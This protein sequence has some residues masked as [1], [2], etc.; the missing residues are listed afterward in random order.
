MTGIA[1]TSDTGEWSP[2]HHAATNSI[3]D[4]SQMDSWFHQELDSLL[5][6]RELLQGERALP[7]LIASPVHAQLITPSPQQSIK[8]LSVARQRWR[9]L[10][11]RKTAKKL[12]PRTPAETRLLQ[13]RRAR[14]RAAPQSSSPEERK[15]RY[16]LRHLLRKLKREEPLPF[17]V[18]WVKPS[19]LC[20]NRSCL[21]TVSSD[22]DHP[23]ASKT[24][25]TDSESTLALNARN[26]PLVVPRR[27]ANYVLNSLVMPLPM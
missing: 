19:R 21:R 18:E 6:E 9:R 26:P 4:T 25:F 12:R 7:I 24:L 5:Q 8:N 2:D 20:P 23:T 11:L 17:P 3:T 13:I 1:D 10:A 22:S 14:N 16:T 15:S 27:R